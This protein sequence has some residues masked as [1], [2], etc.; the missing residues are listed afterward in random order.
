MILEIRDADGKVVCEAPEPKGVAGGLARRPRSSS[1]TSCQGN[2]DTQQNPIWS[3]TLALHNGQ[4]RQHRPAAVKTGTANDARDLATYGFL[5]PPDGSEGAGARGRH[6][7][8][9]QRPL[10]PALGEARRPR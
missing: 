10:E 3:A 5:A 1:P 7:D 4:G 8:G 9:Q 2:T 6:L